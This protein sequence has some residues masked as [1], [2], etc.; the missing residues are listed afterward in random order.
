MSCHTVERIVRSTHDADEFVQVMTRMASYAQVSQP[1]KPQVRM[2]QSRAENPEKFRKTAEWLATINVSQGPWQYDLKT[3][4][5]VKGRGTHVLITEYD[6][7]RKTIEPHDV[8]VDAQG[9]VWY[10]NFGE[11]FLG[12]LDPEDRQGERSCRCRN[13][14]RAIRPARSTSS[15]T[16]PA[17]SGSA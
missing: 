14:R 5:R 13:T 16:R 1:I 12:K 11:M 8:I 17:T 7:P 2:E 4:P 6:L 3:L 9:Q 15:S 10:S